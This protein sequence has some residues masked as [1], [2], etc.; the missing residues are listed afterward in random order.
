MNSSEATGRE[1]VTFTSPGK[2]R[3]EEWRQDQDR[4]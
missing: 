3:A 1:R 2:G 4:G